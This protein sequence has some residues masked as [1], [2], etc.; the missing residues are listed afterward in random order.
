MSYCHECNKKP[1]TPP[2]ALQVINPCDPV[3]FHKVTYPASLGDDTTNPPETLDYKNVLLFYE[4]NNHAYLYSSD[5]VPTFI[6]MGTLD[7][8]QIM[9][10]LNE[11]GIRLT[12]LDNEVTELNTGLENAN[13]AIL[14]TNSDL[15]EI[16]ASLL[17]D[18]DNLDTK[19]STN[20]SSITTINSEI[21]T[22]QSS[23]E[24]ETNARQQADAA[25]QTQISA[26]ATKIAEIES[27]LNQ[28]VEQ[29]TAFN[30]NDS[31]VEVVHT[32]VNLSNNQTLETTDALPVASTTDAG[33]MN[34][35]TYSA[36]QENSELIDSILNGA[37]AIS[38]LPEVP[39]QEELTTR[40]KAASGQTE[41]INRASI[42]D[43]TNQKVWYYYGNVAAWQATSSDGSSVTVSQAT[44]D[45]LGII[46]GSI[47]EGQAFVEADGSLSVN[48]WDNTQE[49]ISNLQAVTEQVDN[50]TKNLPTQVLYNV[51]VTKFNDDDVELNLVLKDLATGGDATIPITLTAASSAQAGIMSKE[52]ATT[53][54]ETA[55]QLAVTMQDVDDALGDIA[56]IQADYVSKDAN[57]AYYEETEETGGAV[58]FPVGAIYI[59]VTSENPSVHFGGTWEA[60]ATG[61]TLIGVDPSDTDFNEV[62][63]TGGEKTHTL[64][65]DEMPAHNHAARWASSTSGS[66]QGLY[67][68]SSGTW[69]YSYRT[70]STG[71][72]E[73]HNNLQPYITVYMWRRTA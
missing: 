57:V 17:S 43:I 30:S 1:E 46:K 18:I 29:S 14:E 15:A 50:R 69:G 56:A 60:F 13:E 38:G 52:Q 31:T 8:E 16:H 23:F 68:G 53:L 42:F 70:T 39:T 21:T 58:I 3:L 66:D 27:N 22:L 35:A 49:A 12:T 67:I 6:S 72:G 24:D 7:A 25:L 62:M 55:S 61:K 63:E 5:G 40:W 65:I 10:I 2:A 71:D 73:A 33:I 64:T 32:K 54:T 48:G 59:S 28:E 34:A 36:V 47:L 4:A 45:S 41:L 19:V 44:N 51:S 9:A 26:A 20:T 37:V 11:H